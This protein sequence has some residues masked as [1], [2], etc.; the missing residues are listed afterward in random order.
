MI[1]IVGLMLL[2]KAAAGLNTYTYVY[3]KLVQ[4]NTLD[5]CVCGCEGV[6]FVGVPSF[7][8]VSGIISI[9]G[10]QYYHIPRLS[11]TISGMLLRF[12]WFVG[13]YMYNTCSVHVLITTSPV[14]LHYSI[15]LITEI[16]AVI[17]CASVSCTD[18]WPVC[19]CISP[20]HNLYNACEHLTKMALN[21]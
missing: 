16:I 9:L 3:H 20:S 8:I 13:C 11:Y 21:K 4:Y 19:T 12:C 10:V 2:E 6:T 14:I 15:I 17:A 18:G 7:Q 5:N 1:F